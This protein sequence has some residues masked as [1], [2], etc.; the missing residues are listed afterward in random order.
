MAHREVEDNHRV[1]QVLQLVKTGLRSWGLEYLMREQ[2]YPKILN[3]VYFTIPR[4][5]ESLTQNIK[6]GR[7]HV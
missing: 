3:G 1:K 7:A 6:I 5:A 2:V 4:R